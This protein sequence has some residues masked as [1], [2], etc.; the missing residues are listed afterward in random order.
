MKDLKHTH[1][2]YKLQLI[3]EEHHG[4]KWKT[5]CIR[6]AKTN[7]CLSVVGAVDRY[8]SER[9]PATALLMSKAPE[10]LEALRDLLVMVEQKNAGDYSGNVDTSE[11]IKAI[12]QATGE[13]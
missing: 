5:Y 4:Y 9:I 12:N 7:V 1:G 11:A 3:E 10:L 6:S 13:N 8:E 2:P